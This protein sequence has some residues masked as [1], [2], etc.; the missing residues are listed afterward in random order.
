M[1]RAFN[2]KLWALCGIAL[3]FSACSEDSVQ[4]PNN[5]AGSVSNFNTANFTVRKSDQTRASS[6][7][8]WSEDHKC[9]LNDDV[10]DFSLPAG[11]DKMTSPGW[12]AA[13]VY[14]IPASYN[15]AVSFEWGKLEDGFKLYNFGTVTE[16]KDVNIEGKIT[17]YNDGT[18]TWN[19]SSGSRHMFVNTGALTI[20]NY[21]NIGEV[22][23]KGHLVL[24]RSNQWW[25]DPDDKVD[26]PNAMSIYS[27]GTIEIPNKNCD[28]KAAC[29]IH[30][31]VNAAGNVKIQNQETQYICGL[32][33]AG[34]LDM[35]QG[36]LQTSYVKAKEI[37]FDGAEMWLLPEAYVGAEKISMINSAT[38]IHGY[39]DSYAL[40]EADDFFFRNMNNFESAFSSNIS[41]KVNGTIDI[42]EILRRDNGQQ[43][44]EKSI[45]KTVEDYLASQNG[46][47]LADRFNGEELSGTPECGDSYGTPGET[48]EEPEGPTLELIGSIEAP[49][50][51]HDI[52]KSDPNRRHLSATCIDFKDGV[53]Y[54]SYHMRGGNY[55]GDTY[56]K[57]DVEG[58]IETWTIEKDKEKNSDVVTLGNW[59]WTNG[60]DF[61]HLIID[62]SNIVTVGHYGK[63]GAII[64]KMTNTFANFDAEENNADG[65]SDEFSFKYLTTAEPL[66]DKG[67]NGEIK[68]DYKNAGDGNCVIRV[69]DEYF[70]STYEGYGKLDLE[71]NR[72]KDEDGKVAFVPTPGS[73]KHIIEKGGDI[74]VLYLN[75]RP[76]ST[77]T[78]KSSATLAT[79]SKDNFPF[80]AATSELN[81]YV[82]PVDGKNVLA[83]NDNKMFACLGKG[84]LNV[85]NEIY[86]FGEENKEPVNGIAFDGPYVYLASGS[87]LRVLDASTMEEVTHYCIPNMSANYIKVATVNGE[88]VI[89]VAFGQ[90]GIKVF[91]LKNN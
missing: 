53:F 28:F 72:I 59:M 1:K 42:E 87:H 33:V 88:K 90:A 67:E 51:D 77:A 47:A 45:Y 11:A 6:M 81:S 20:E 85:D 58:C 49:S 18:L 79:V 82:Q 10:F 86:T 48:P 43:D 8:T 36:H 56:D 55:A 25:N 38:A 41:F 44:N 22:Y 61:N 74:A 31:M 75:E 13:G 54:V 3:A 23:N 76:T 62:G 24:T 29:D 34:T 7:G 84:G 9:K 2:L 65:K 37:K 80:G 57:D 78:A 19:L 14:V 68:T 5:G 64:G 63:K 26:I 39:E 70:V 66:M 16:L 50:H 73:A 35:T 4:G 71:F 60:F 12:A 83:W 30:N 32:K 91:K 17:V 69:N 52:D 40:V 89:A 15:G 27:D 46:E 21:A